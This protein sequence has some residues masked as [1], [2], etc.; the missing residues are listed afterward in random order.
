MN[1]KPLKWILMLCF[2]VIAVGLAYLSDCPSDPGR[3]W[4]IAIS[5]VVF[6]NWNVNYF[7]GL[8]MHVPYLPA[9]TDGEREIVVLVTWIVWIGLILV[10]GIA[11][12]GCSL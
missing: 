6:F 5:S 4:V 9:P 1:K 10:G 12:M 8:P 3:P 2:S 11:G 7:F